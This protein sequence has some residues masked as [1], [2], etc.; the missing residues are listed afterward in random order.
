[1]QPSGDTNEPC[2]PCFNAF[3]AAARRSPNRMLPLRRNVPA[4]IYLTSLTSYLH[5][6]CILCLRYGY[7]SVRLCLAETR[8]ALLLSSLKSHL[9]SSHRP[10]AVRGPVVSLTSSINQNHVEGLLTT[11]GNSSSGA[12]GHSLA[13]LH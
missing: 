8:S 7:L 11:I 1:M 13:R 5:R 3:P 2:L 12:P 9:F 10:S 6:D 4:K